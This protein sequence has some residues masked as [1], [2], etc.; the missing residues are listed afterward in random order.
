MHRTASL[1]RKELSRCFLTS[2]ASVTLS[3]SAQKQLQSRLF[4][5]Y[6]AIASSVRSCLC[7]VTSTAASSYGWKPRSARRR[8]DLQLTSELLTR[9]SQSST[10]LAACTSHHLMPASRII[11]NSKLLFQNRPWQMQANNPGL[12]SLYAPRFCAHIGRH[13]L[14]HYRRPDIPSF[15]KVI[16]AGQKLWLLNTIG[17]GALGTRFGTPMGPAPPIPTTQALSMMN[18]SEM[19]TLMQTLIANQP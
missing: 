7:S 18:L 13:C 5:C 1:L 4:I 8:K 11:I 6:G 17:F 10:T 19:S 3:S 2:R 14:H 15:T 16:V 9:K 12:L